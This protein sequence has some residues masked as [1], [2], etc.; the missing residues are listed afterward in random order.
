MGPPPPSTA[1]TVAQPSEG[2]PEQRPAARALPRASD[3]ILLRLVKNLAHLMGGQTVNAAVGV[4]SIALIARA[5]GPELLGVLATI[6]AY[7]RTV[8]RLARIETWQALVR[9]GAADLENGRFDV[10]RRIVK[11]GVVVDLCS[12]LAAA[13]CAILFAPLVG[14]WLDWND[15]T[16]RI[17]QLYCLTLLFHMASTPVGVLRLLNRF[18]AIAWAEAL[19]GV[20]RLLLVITAFAAGFG[21]WAFVLLSA[22]VQVGMW[23]GLMALAWRELAAAGLGGFLR[24][25]LGS[26]QTQWPG[27]WGFI[28]SANATGIVRRSTQE[29]DTLI[30]GSVLGPAATG[31]YHV[32]KRLGSAVTKGGNLMQQALF[33]DLARLWARGQ[34]RAFAKAVLQITLATAGLAAVALLVVA[35]G[36]DRIVLLIAGPSFAEAAAPMVAQIAAVALFLSASGFR[37]AVMTMGLHFGILKVSIAASV[38]FYLAL[39]LFMPQWGVLGASLAHV[40]FSLVWLPAMAALFVR[41]LRTSPAAS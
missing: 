13:G 35:L 23:L 28:W 7:A 5:L 39:L 30:V 6:E 9:Y 18:A 1:E 16:L 4:V 3:D 26:T 25:P 29:L 40:A 15:E 37:P 34:K 24:A 31:V 10:F 32:A 12:S 8:D 2:S 20:V 19:T 14:Q 41:G 11:F 17:A 22:V 36:S 21:L 27:I 38:V 33:P